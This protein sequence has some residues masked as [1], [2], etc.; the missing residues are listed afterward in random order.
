MACAAPD[1]KAIALTD[2]KIRDDRTAHPIWDSVEEAN[3]KVHTAHLKNL[4]GSDAVVNNLVGHV[5]AVK[6]MHTYTVSVVWRAGL[7]AD[8]DLDDLV[9][10]LASNVHHNPSRLV[11]PVPLPFPVHQAIILSD[12]QFLRF[13]GVKVLH[14]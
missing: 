6:L 14:M 12:A 11:R 7:D 10:H 3:L 8:R 13:K 4:R 5:H 9:Q 2:V 1:L